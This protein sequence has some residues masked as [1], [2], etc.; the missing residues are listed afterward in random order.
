M[1]T[2]EKVFFLRFLLNISYGA[3]LF[4]LSFFITLKSLKIRIIIIYGWKF[5]VLVNKP[6]Y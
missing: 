1:C 5:L 3:F 4:L 6:S 2:T